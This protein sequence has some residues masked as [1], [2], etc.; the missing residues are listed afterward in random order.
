MLRPLVAGVLYHKPD[1]LGD[2]KRSPYY[3]ADNRHPH[4]K[5]CTWVGEQDASPKPTSDTHEPELD[6]VSEELGL[7]FNPTSG[8]GG[9]GNPK[10]APEPGEDSDSDEKE[11]RADKPAKLRPQT[12]KF[13]ELVASRY[14]IYTDEQRKNTE[15]GIQGKAKGSFY[16]ICLPIRFFSPHAQENRIYR[17]LVTVTALSNVYLVKFASWIS[18]EGKKDERTTRAEV[19]L[20]KRWLEENDR[21]LGD[22]LHDLAT[23]KVRAHCF[24]YSTSPPLAKDKST[25]YIEI[26]DPAHFA[27]IPEDEIEPTDSDS[28]A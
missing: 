25:V 4:I 19:K 27:L 3:R 5:T 16:T 23:R 7:V 18:P 11:S 14:L 21:A 26:A 13:M 6:S 15:L 10:V 17:G 20:T 1:E 24:V 12:C 9:K 8:K 28:F 2:K 22:V